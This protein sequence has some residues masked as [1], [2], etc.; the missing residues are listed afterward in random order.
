MS[1][2][3][4]LHSHSPSFGRFQK[5]KGNTDK[6]KHFR[7][8]LREKEKSWDY[9]T[10]GVKKP[11]NRTH[12]YIISKKDFD[13]L[14]ELSKNVFFFEIRTNIEHYIG[15]KPQAMKVEDALKKLNNKKFKI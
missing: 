14:I 7:N 3:I 1:R 5:I 6:I 11:K 8:E 9:I 13:K 10:L 2:N 15:K 4:T 12:L